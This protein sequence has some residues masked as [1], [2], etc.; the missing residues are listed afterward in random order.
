MLFPRVAHA[1]IQVQKGCTD[2]QAAD[3][4][5]GGSRDGDGAGVMVVTMEHGAAAN[6]AMNGVAGSCV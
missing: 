1:T 6:I 5:L 4:R 2:A 3:S